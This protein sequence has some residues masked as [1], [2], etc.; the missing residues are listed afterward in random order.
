MSSIHTLV[1]AQLYEGFYNTC[2]IHPAPLHKAQ[3][4]ACAGK[5]SGGEEC[6]TPAW[7]SRLSISLMG[8]L[9]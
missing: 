9:G 3:N 1:P 2:H 5:A 4:T 6:M 8:R 7:G